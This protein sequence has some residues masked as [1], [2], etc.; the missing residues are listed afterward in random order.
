MGDDFCRSVVC[1]EV[2]LL[3]IA[4]V[5]FSVQNC[6]VNILSRMVFREQLVYVI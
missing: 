5:G 4:D 3:D 1:L 6:D 2:L